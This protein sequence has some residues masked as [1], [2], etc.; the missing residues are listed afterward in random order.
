M[1]K[2]KELFI[3]L[4]ER[5]VL[6]LYQN[7]SQKQPLLNI[8]LVQNTVFNYADKVIEHYTNLFFGIEGE[9]DIEEAGEVAKMVLNDKIEEYRKK[10]KEQKSS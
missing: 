9:I 6:N 5:D 4:I 2:D 8:P 7:L 3:Q 10:I 1:L